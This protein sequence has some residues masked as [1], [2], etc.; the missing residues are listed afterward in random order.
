VASDK[1]Y[2]HLLSIAKQALEEKAPNG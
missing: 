2:S 1:E